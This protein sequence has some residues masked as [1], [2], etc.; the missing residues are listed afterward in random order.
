MRL[1]EILKLKWRAGL[2]P[3]FYLQSFYFSDKMAF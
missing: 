1:G 3:K 2:S